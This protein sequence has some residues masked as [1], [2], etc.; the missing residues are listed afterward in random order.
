M[1]TKTK[2]NTSGIPDDVIIGPYTYNVVIRKRPF[3]ANEK[4]HP[5][6]TAGTDLLGYTD[7]ASH[8]IDIAEG[9]P[10][11]AMADTLLHEILHGVCDVVGMCESEDVNEEKVIR[12]IT[13]TLIDV[14]RRNPK[15]VEYIL[16]A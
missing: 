11:A 1:N 14:F 16:T 5:K 4:E 12:M 9:V 2:K 15:V 8:R 6:E 10:P 13:P 3:V 7:T